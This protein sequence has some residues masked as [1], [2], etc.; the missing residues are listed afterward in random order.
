VGPQ[1]TK[2]QSETTA[3]SVCLQKE[4]E[5]DGREAG[6]PQAEGQMVLQ[7]QFEDTGFGNLA[8]TLEKRLGD[9]CGAAPTA[10]TRDS[11]DDPSSAVTV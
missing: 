10:E 5:N 2:R 8:F 11:T 9:K 7:F 1:Q 3:F 4:N 6:P